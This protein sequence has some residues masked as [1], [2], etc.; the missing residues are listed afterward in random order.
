MYIYVYKKCERNKEQSD[1]DLS[2]MASSMPCPLVITKEIVLSRL[3]SPT[4][5]TMYV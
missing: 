5:Q 3:A 1:A 4:N 2:I